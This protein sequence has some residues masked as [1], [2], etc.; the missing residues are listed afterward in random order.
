[1]SCI[2]PDWRESGT[3]TVSDSHEILREYLCFGCGGG[4][5]CRNLFPAHGPV[6]GHCVDINK[7]ERLKRIKEE[8]E[9]FVHQMRVAWPEL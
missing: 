3:I 7:L 5:V 1:M 6:P 9:S 2:K 8:A 4:Q